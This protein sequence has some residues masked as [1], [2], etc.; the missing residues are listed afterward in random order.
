MGHYPSVRLMSVCTSSNCDNAGFS[1]PSFGQV[2]RSIRTGQVGYVIMGS[3][4]HFKQGCVR[5]KGCLSGIFILGRVHFVTLGGGCSGIKNC[6]GTIG[7]LVAMNMAGIAGR[8]CTTGASL[9]IQKALGLEQRRNGFV[10]SFTACNCLGSP[11]SHRGL[12]ISP[13]TTPVIRVVFRQFMNNR[14]VV[15]VAGSLGRVNVPGPS[16]CGGLGKFGCGRPTNGD[17]SKL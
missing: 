5:I 3:L 14:D 10:N 4:S 12:V 6:G 17:G 1:H 13:S 11:S 8:A 2:V 16:V 15:N 9:G 7:G